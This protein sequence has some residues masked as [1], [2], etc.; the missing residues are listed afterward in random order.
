MSY[1]SIE[2]LSIK[3]GEFELKSLNLNLDLGDYAVIIGPTGSGKS[4]LLECII[5]F[6]RPETGKIILD[7]KNII[8]DLP[9]KRGISIV[10]QDYALLPHLTVFQNIAYGLRKVKRKIKKNIIKEKV[11][12]IAVSLKIDHLLDRSPATLSGGEQQRTALARSLI[13]N[14]RLLLM[15]EP[16]SAL[17]PGTRK[18]I[19]SLLC[20]VIDKKCTTVIHVTH[21]MKDQWALADKT[22]I[23]QK[24]KVVQSGAVRDIFERPVNKFVADFV[25]ASFFKAEVD[26]IVN[27]ATRVK[28][29]DFNLFSKDTADIGEKV[30]IAVRPEEIML[31]DNP[32]DNLNGDNLFK[33][34]VE[35]IKCEGEV[36]ALNIRA[37]KTLFNVNSTRNMMST[38]YPKPGD[39]LYARIGA[40][41]VRI[42]R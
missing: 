38:I 17:D 22:I 24:G 3:L 1:L 15:D 30:K 23:L 33:T 40:D 9:E 7:G 28:I 35:R 29:D 10:Y 34:R 20:D 27:G 4:I 8:N 32:P 42:V 2:N 21:Y 16:F 5:G 41:N 36:W 12:E 6:F 18:E 39:M 11:Q 26:S 19:R 31:Y 25:G 37:G 13:V 14:P